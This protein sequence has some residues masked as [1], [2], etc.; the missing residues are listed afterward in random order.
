M[1]RNEMIQTAYL[2]HA[3]LSKV[4]GGANEQSCYWNSRALR[5]DLIGLQEALH[6]FSFWRLWT[7]IVGPSNRKEMLCPMQIFQTE[8]I[9]F[10]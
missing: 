1:T 3:T 7:Y 10:R 8:K 6:H 5:H 9:K 4:S 2:K